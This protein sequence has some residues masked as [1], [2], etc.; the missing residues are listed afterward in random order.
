MRRYILVL[1]LVTLLLQP[2]P[3]SSHEE[4]RVRLGNEVLLDEHLDGLQSKSVGLVTNH[5]GVNS[6]G[7]HIAYILAEDERVHLVALYAPE[8]GLDGEAAAGEYVESY[9]HEELDVPVY[10][11]YGPT[12]K[13]TSQ[14]LD[15][16]D[17]L[18]FDIQDIGA[19]TYTY[20]S[21]MNYCM[22]AAAENHVPIWILDRPNPL[23]GIGVEGPVLEESFIS[24]VGIDEL[25]K[26]HG[27]TAGELAQFFNREIGADLEIIEMQG[28]RRNMIFPDTGLPW[29]QTSPNI[30][31]LDSCFGY[32][33]TGLGQ[34]TGVYQADQFTWIGG[35]GLDSE[36]FHARL[37]SSDLPGVQFTPDTRN[38]VGGVQITITDYY[39]FNPA[40]TGIHALAHAFLLGDFTVP[41]SDNEIVMFEKIMGTDRMG[42]WLERGLTPEKME[43]EY[44]AELEQFAKE[45]AEYLIGAYAQEV[46]VK[47]DDTLLQFD[48]APMID[49]NH[50]TLVPARAIAEALGGTV[51][52]DGDA[53][54]VTIIREDSIVQ[55][56]I[57]RD[58]AVVDGRE[59][60]MDTHP[61]I[62][63]DRTLIPVRYISE[64][65]GA[66]VS[67]NGHWQIVDIN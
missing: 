49:S 4:P 38:G 40:R 30:P 56:H 28:Y 48:V 58:T 55:F 20:M 61:I 59:K 43:R 19:R 25:P 44:A 42:D 39:D 64:F 8:H 23:G 18:L 35:A 24:F 10:S 22:V 37:S 47:I 6:R 32:M 15:N 66:D 60:L 67:W 1:G 33:A 45:R 63:E 27:M 50:R 2:V 36:A 54:R 14:M 21:T 13:P 29:V 9:T 46:L 53:R 41:R 11:L 65:L 34:G 16:V 51:E 31:D 52:W 26:A 5:T 57:G 7:E 17:M 62:V 3:V 12:R